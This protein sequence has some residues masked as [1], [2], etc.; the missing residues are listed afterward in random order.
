MRAMGR[1]L[2]DAASGNSE[3]GQKPKR[4]SGDQYVRLADDGELIPD[5]QQSSA[6]A[7]KAQRSARG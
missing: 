2:A 1:K 5:E 6:K 3:I 7:Q 4:E